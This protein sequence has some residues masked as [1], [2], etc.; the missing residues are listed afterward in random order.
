M[1]SDEGV[2]WEAWL[3]W[4][5]RTDIDRLTWHEMHLLPTFAPER[6]RQ[7]LVDDP[8]AGIVSGIVRRAWTQAG[9]RLRLARD[10]AAELE[11]VGLGPVMLAGPVAA[12]ARCARPGAVRPVTEIHLALP[13]EGCAAAVD[14]LA[15]AG[16]LLLDPLPRA[17]EYNWKTHLMLQRDDLVLRLIWRHVQTTPWRARSCEADLFRSTESVMPLEALLLSVAAGGSGGDGLVPWQADC[18]VLIPGPVDWPAVAAAAAAYAPAAFDRL[19]LLRE[20]GAAVPDLE[21]RGSS[22]AR[23]EAALARVLKAVIL[24]VRGR[25]QGR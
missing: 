10:L 8:A 20:L 16:W 24:E 3:R 2:A 23:A 7:F 13:R 22:M 9:M 6:L 12:F 19:D 21:R 14:R 5:E 18:G 1:T 25:I 15:P 11:A 17:K 4:R